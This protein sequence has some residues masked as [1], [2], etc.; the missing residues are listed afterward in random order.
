MSKPGYPPEV[1]EVTGQFSLN[2]L[3]LSQNWKKIP[4][5]TDLSPAAKLWPQKIE[6]Y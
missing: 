3:S 2:P 5:T 4:P 6:F 1:T